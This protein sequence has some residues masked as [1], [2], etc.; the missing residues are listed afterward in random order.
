MPS[1]VSEQAMHAG[2]DKPDV[3]F[4]VHWCISKAIEVDN[5][6]LQI[7]MPGITFNASP[8]VSYCFM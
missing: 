6:I 7:M 8:W 2:I 3:R 1:R 4:V 5:C